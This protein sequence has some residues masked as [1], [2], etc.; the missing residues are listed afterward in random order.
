VVKLNK[1][2]PFLCSDIDRQGRKRWRLRAPG[3]PT[4]TIKGEYGSQEFVANYRAAMEGEPAKP[5]VIGRHGTFDALGRAY[6]RSAT[7]SR[8]A[9]ATQRCRR[10]LV[11]GFLD[12][13]GALSVAG[14]R[15][16]HVKKIMD[17][18]PPGMARSALAMLRALVALAI[19]D[20]IRNDDPTANIKRPKLSKDGWHAWTDDEIAAFEDKHAI[21]TR[22]RLHFALALYTGQRS[23]DLIKMGRQHMRDGTISVVQQKTG[24]R[25][26]IPIHPELR[27]IID[28]TPT[29][30]LAF[31]ISEHGRPYAGA[32]S[33]SSAM[34]RWARQ[35]GLTGCPLHGLRKACARRLAEAGCSA[36]EIMSITGH[37]TLSEVERYTRSADQIRMSRSAMG[38]VSGTL[39]YPQRRPR[40]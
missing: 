26:W 15:H 25:L 28:A 27:R 3:R 9:V 23:S 17:G 2:Y 37:K 21:G 32:H 4:V 1:P 10:G 11:E 14:L 22:A 39:K 33:L 18:Y 24:T 31:M 38:K 7:F 5:S 12:K 29:G 16:E 34:N 30:D 13:Y 19:E 36:L 35:A 6:L 40:G 20:G 8:L